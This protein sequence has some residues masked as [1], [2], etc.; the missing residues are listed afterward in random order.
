MLYVSE[1]KTSAPA[2]Y[3]THLQELVYKTLAELK[4][5]FERV[6]TD[7]VI[8]ME[9]CAAVNDRLDMKM[10]KTLFLCDRKQ[11]G[12]YLFIT[13]GAKPFRSKE[14]SAAMG[15]SRLSFAPAGLMEQILGTAVGA[16][17]VFSALLDTAREVKIV[18]DKDVVS[19]QWYGCSDGTTKGY[20]KI[21][22][23]G[24]LNV[25]LPHTGHKPAIVAV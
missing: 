2:E 1:V 7:E 8:T 9:D 21:E 10:V 13:A 17:T 16:A 24:I 22:T 23:A 5:A 19:Q 4:I 18:F 3:K 12:F 15:V 14:F 6:D 11:T 25:F 20:M